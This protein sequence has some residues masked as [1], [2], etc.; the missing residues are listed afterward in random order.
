MGPARPGEPR[1]DAALASQ[2]SRPLAADLISSPPNMLHG[3]RLR[4]AAARSARTPDLPGASW[5]ADRRLAASPPS[6]LSDCH[7][8]PGGVVSQV[9]VRPVGRLISPVM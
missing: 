6:P 7:M 5:A 1:P 9:L 2:R 8:L 4:R 3:A